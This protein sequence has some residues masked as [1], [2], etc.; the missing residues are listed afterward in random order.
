MANLQSAQDMQ[1]QSPGGNIHRQSNMFDVQN[2]YFPTPTEPGISNEQTPGTGPLGKQKANQR[3]R[4][5]KPPISTGNR[6]NT[7]LSIRTP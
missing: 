7:G 2:E 4:Q 3:L 1:L 5:G 6:K